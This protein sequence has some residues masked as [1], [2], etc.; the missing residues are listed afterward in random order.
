MDADI[1]GTSD[2]SQIRSQLDQLIEDAR[3]Y[4]QGPEYQELL[5]FVSRMQTFAPFNAMLLHLQKPGLSYAATARHWLKEFGRSPKDAARPL[6]IMQPFGPVALVYDVQDTEGFPLPDSAS[7][8][9]ATGEISATEIHSLLSLIFTLHVSCTMVD[10]GDNHAGSIRVTRWP[11]NK[12]AGHYS[13]NLNRNHAPAVQFGTLVHELA[14][15]CLGHLGADTKQEIPERRAVPHPQRELEAESV[16]YLVSKRRGLEPNSI[17]YLSQFFRGAE[18]PSMP[19]TYQ[20][21]RVAGRIERLVE[22]RLSGAA[23]SPGETT[24]EKWRDE[25]YRFDF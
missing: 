18:P 17:P 25:Q 1:Q 20:V 23:H 10:A 5:D 12:E 3:L 4:R 19:D 9:T 15:L 11:T 24:A 7:A 13:L 16:S 14:H 2:A 21:M 6:L 8:F 22:P